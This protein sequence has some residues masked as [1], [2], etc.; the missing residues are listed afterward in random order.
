VLT[1]FATTEY[2]KRLRTAHTGVVNDQVNRRKHAGRLGQSIVKL[3]KI[4]VV[5]AATAC[6]TLWNS[7]LGQCS[8][9]SSLTITLRAAW[10][11]GAS[12]GLCM[13]FG[14]RVHYLFHN[15][16]RQAHNTVHRSHNWRHNNQGILLG[17]MKGP[18]STLYQ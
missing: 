7:T 6:D 3:L 18:D 17:L 9:C 5:I 2:V 15:A 16:V 8:P 1:S 14:G 13:L 12:C 10:Y 11:A 4:G